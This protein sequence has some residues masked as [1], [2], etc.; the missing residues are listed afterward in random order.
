VLKCCTRRTHGALP[1][2]VE[3]LH[4]SQIERREIR[5]S[6]G[7][8]FGLY[9]RVAVTEPLTG[10]ARQRCL[11]RCG[12]SNSAVHAVVNWRHA[13]EKSVTR[14]WRGGEVGE[15][16]PMLA[17]LYRRL[18]ALRSSPLQQH[19]A[20]LF[21]RLEHLP[22]G[23]SDGG[24]W[25]PVSADQ[26]PDLPSERIRPDLAKS[27]RHALG[28]RLRH[29]EAAWQALWGVGGPLFWLDRAPGYSI[30]PGRSR[31]YRDCPLQLREEPGAIAGCAAS[32]HSKGALV[33]T[34]ASRRW[35]LKALKRYGLQVRISAS[36]SRVR[37]KSWG[38]AGRSPTI[39]SRTSRDCRCAHPRCS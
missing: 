23:S 22:A 35:A 25:A 2:N 38:V 21:N 33:A 13:G 14:C 20:P 19:R 17:Q 4:C 7:Q 27:E 24:Y 37:E 1:T 12:G 36:R 39:C 3:D 26:Q 34:F 10:A 11:G 31:R 32:Q 8:R 9:G 6:D 28:S 30:C 18:R 16:V 29:P 5:A 15:I